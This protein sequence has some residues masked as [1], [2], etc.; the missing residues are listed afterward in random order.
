MKS[1]THRFNVEG[2]GEVDIDV[3]ERM[4]EK[5]IKHCKKNHE[6]KREQ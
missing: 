3:T 2:I 5:F 6:N 4:H 1:Y